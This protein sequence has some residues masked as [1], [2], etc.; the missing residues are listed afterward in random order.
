MEAAGITH[1]DS[2]HFMELAA[3]ASN[4]GNQSTV[5]SQPHAWGG[6]AGTPRLPG[7]C[8][9]VRNDVVR[10]HLLLLKLATISSSLSA[11]ILTREFMPQFRNGM[12]NA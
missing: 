2:L 4:E 11:I 9:A 10:L 12:S 1:T 5:V 6:I 7:F 8:A 3:W